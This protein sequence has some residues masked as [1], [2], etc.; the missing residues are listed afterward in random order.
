M[1][2][3]NVKQYYQEGKIRIM[4]KVES[5]KDYIDQD[6][7]KNFINLAIEIYNITNFINKDYPQYKE[8]FFK[9][10]L[11]QIKT[12][13]RNILFIRNPINYNEIIA[14]TCLKKN[15]EEQKIC[16]LYVSKKFRALGIGSTIIEESIKWLGTTTPLITFPEHKQDMFKN[17]IKKYNWQLTKTIENLYNNNSNELCY[18]GTVTKKLTK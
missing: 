10:Q 8:W 15:K 16:T 1:Y 5:L 9:T 18:N 12:N 4:I 6:N 7:K 11:P 13:E 17:F 3:Y 14:M 2:N